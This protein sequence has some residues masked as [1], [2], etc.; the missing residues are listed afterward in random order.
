[1]REKCIAE[2][3]AR[4][5]RE[6]GPEQSDGP[7]RTPCRTPAEIHPVVAKEDRMQ[8]VAMIALRALA[9]EDRD[10]KARGDVDG[11]TPGGGVNGKRPA[12][13]GELHKGRVEED[14]PRRLSENDEQAS[15]DEAHEHGAAA[16]PWQPA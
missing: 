3:G 13:P 11:K 12:A 5:E 6:E 4:A 16:H 1:M 10:K 15:K 9:G 8:G 7:F 2:D 14:E